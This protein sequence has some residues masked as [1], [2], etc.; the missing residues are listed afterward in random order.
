MGNLHGSKERPVYYAAALDLRG[1]LC[2]VIGGGTVAERKLKGLLDGGADRV[3]LVSPAVTPGIA[4]LAEAGNVDLELRPFE[5]RDLEDVWLA[6]AC[7]D[8]PA[9]NAA[10]ALAAE[11]RRLWCNKADDAETGGFISPSAVR[12]GDLLLA[13]TAS[14]ASPSLS[15]MI[16]GELERQYGPRYE[17]GVERLRRLREF[18]Y[19]A[20][21]DD[22][23]RR[24]VL[25]LAAEATMADEDSARELEIEKWYTV[26][27]E[28]TK[29][30]QTE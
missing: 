9:L 6:F 26:L 18:A 28:R 1:R 29:G 8:D 21:S 23:L 5:E 10:I 12:R 19:E 16:R 13:V 4:A 22:R 25:R 11:R 17:S 14:G 7:T 2:A 27:L 20:E 15:A 24:G 3:R 30:R